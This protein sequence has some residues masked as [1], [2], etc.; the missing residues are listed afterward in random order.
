MK[1]DQK[2]YREAIYAS[3]AVRKGEETPRKALNLIRFAID[4]IAQAGKQTHHP[5]WLS[6]LN[7]C[8]VELSPKV[9]RKA[10]AGGR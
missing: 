4:E 3:K 7:W 1:K 2:A 8:K 9:A 6:E 10:K 5:L